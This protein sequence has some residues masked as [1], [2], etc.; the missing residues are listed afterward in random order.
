M[1]LVYYSQTILDVTAGVFEDKQTT[2]SE[3]RSANA[4][5]PCI[6]RCGSSCHAEK[7]ASREAHIDNGKNA[8]ALLY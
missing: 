2:H 1:D 8:V 5:R 3:H 4:H 6:L 7:E